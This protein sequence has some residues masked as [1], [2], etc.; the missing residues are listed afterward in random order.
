[1]NNFWRIIFVFTG[2]LSVFVSCNRNTAKNENADVINVCINKIIDHEALNETIRGIQDI[3]ATSKLQFRVTVESSQGSSVMAQ[4]L[5]DKFVSGKANVIIGVGTIAAQSFMKYAKDGRTRFVYSSVTDPKSAGLT[6]KQQIS[7]VSNFVELVPQIDLF[8]EILPKLKRLGF[9]YNPG[10]AN[11]VMLISELK[12]I[13]AKRGITL[14]LQTATRTFEIQQAVENLVSKVDAIFISNDNTAL[15]AFKCI[16][17][18][19]GKNKIPVF[20][21]DTDIVHKGALA[22]L[23]P[24]QYKIG[25]QTANLVLKQIKDKTFESLIEYP[26]KE[27]T[28][29][30]VNQRAAQKC[31]IELPD[32]VLKRAHKILV[33]Q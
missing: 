17:N 10:E 12:E 22:A 1:V 2:V 3:L 27:D 21:S 9:L 24:N 6:G 20:V 31:D 19:A 14:V 11:S 32:S 15:S 18:I 30:I 4:Q 5:T 26:R 7:G 33:D 29:L 25:E 23:G 8:L 28:L 13:L 16:R